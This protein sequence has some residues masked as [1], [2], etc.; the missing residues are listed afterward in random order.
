MTKSPEWEGKSLAVGGQ[1][2]LKGVLSKG[3][4]EP[5][6]TLKVVRGGIRSSSNGKKESLQDVVWRDP[7]YPKEANKCSIRRRWTERVVEQ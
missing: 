7:K 4:R 5:E 3:L 6:G 1:M 2:D